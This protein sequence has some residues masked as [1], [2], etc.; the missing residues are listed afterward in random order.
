MSMLHPA[1]IATHRSAFDIAMYR[2]NAGLA[3]GL[4]N[5]TLCYYCLHAVGPGIENAGD[6][7]VPNSSA[8]CFSSADG[9]H[10]TSAKRNDSWH[11]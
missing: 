8:N 4:C 11:C 6:K 1:F 3:C 10:C 7:L 9:S 5:Y 2:Y